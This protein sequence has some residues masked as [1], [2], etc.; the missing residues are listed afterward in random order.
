MSAKGACKPGCKAIHIRE[1]LALH[2]ARQGH[3]CHI[4]LAFG[5]NVVDNG[6]DGPAAGDCNDIAVLEILKEMIARYNAD[7]PQSRVRI[8]RLG[9]RD[10]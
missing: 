9:W 10:N 4:D 7:L 8:S 6:G 3:Y 2:P 1:E 5:F